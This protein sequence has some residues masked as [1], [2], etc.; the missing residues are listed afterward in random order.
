MDTF[1]EDISSMFGV[2]MD[3]DQ[4]EAATLTVKGI[5]KNYKRLAAV[6]SVKTEGVLDGSFHLIFDKEGMFTLAGLIV[7]QPEARIQENRTGGTAAEATDLS[8]AIGEVG[9][10]LIG[11]WDRM[12]REEMEGHGHFVQSKTYIGNVCGDSDEALGLSDTEEFFFVPFEMTVGSYPAFSCGAIFPMGV[13]GSD[14]RADGETE[15]QDQAEDSAEADGPAQPEQAPKEQAKAQAPQAQAEGEAAPQAAATSEAAT[16]SEAEPAG[17]PQETEEAPTEEAAGKA[18]QATADAAAT[19]AAQQSGEPVQEA[20][21]DEEQES[22]QGQGE[23]GAAAAAQK[24]SEPAEEAASAEE[25]HAAPEEDEVEVL[26]DPDDVADAQAEVDQ[27]AEKAAAD[28]SPAGQ[29]SPQDKVAEGAGDDSDKQT[30]GASESIEEPVAAPQGLISE[31]IQKMSRSPAVLPGEQPIVSLRT[32]AVD[33]MCTE[34]AWGSA[35]DTVEQALTKMQQYDAGYMLIGKDGKI[36][37]MVSKSDLAGAVSPY[38]RPA[39]AK[40]RRPLDDATLQLKIKWVMTRPVRTVTPDTTLAKVMEQMCRSGG[41]CLP[42]I[43]KQGQAL[44]LITVFDIFKTLLE[45]DSE[46]KIE[47]KTP[48][49]PPLV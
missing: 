45:Q 22:A 13:F 9:N 20:T 31:T 16:G 1:C 11:S 36:E 10:L 24:E 21:S 34:I 7:M 42:V 26:E 8:D 25:S 27:E 33:V 30:A 12:F 14:A 28:E 46:I 35:D 4:E 3:T 5:K 44:G 43:D 47:G 41:R 19:D 29:E 2:P 17:E 48:Q 40:W 6:Y 39:F 32:Q 37:G 49:G 23:P 15:P 18:E 38:L